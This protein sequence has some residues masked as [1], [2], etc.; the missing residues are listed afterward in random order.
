MVA[1]GDGALLVLGHGAEYALC[2]RSLRVSKSRPFRLW[3][4]EGVWYWK[5]TALKRNRCAANS[6]DT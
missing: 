1:G 2:G 5:V 6:S 3:S 4:L